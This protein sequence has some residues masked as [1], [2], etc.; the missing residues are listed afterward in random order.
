MPN[1]HLLREQTEG[2]YFHFSLSCTGEGN[3]NPLQCSCLENPRDG[4]PGG[5]P[6]MGL[7]RVGYD[8]SDWVAAREQIDGHKDTGGIQRG[9]CS[10]RESSSTGDR[11]LHNHKADF[12]IGTESSLLEVWKDC[13][14]DLCQSPLCLPLFIPWGQETGGGCLNSRTMISKQ[15]L[16]CIYS[17][18][19]SPEVRFPLKSSRWEREIPVF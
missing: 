7:H 17:W 8:W 15:Y 6:S 3:G 12:S 18:Q 11:R 19:G 16:W 13:Q 2:L 4:E 14:Q 9:H 5:L 1:K 10:K